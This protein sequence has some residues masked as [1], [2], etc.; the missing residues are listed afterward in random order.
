MQVC[1]NGI[2]LREKTSR[3]ERLTSAEREY[4]KM[5]YLA[6]IYDTR[7]SFYGKAIVEGNTLYSYGAKV[8]EIKNE[9]PQVYIKGYALTATTLRHIKEFLRQ[10]GFNV[11][12]K[13]DVEVFARV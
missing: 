6:P 12:T 5:K 10:N 4:K 3:A 8:C 9:Q 1:Y 2:K 13:K 11:N 7:K